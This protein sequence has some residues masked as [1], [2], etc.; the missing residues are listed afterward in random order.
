[1]KN[2]LEAVKE[3]H[4]TSCVR[5]RDKKPNDKY[6]IRFVRKQGCWSPVGRQVD[7]VGGQELSI[8][9]GCNEKGIILHELM[10]ALGF[11]H[12]QARTD[13]D[14]YI[15]VLWENVMPGIPV[16]FNRYNGGRLDFV[17][18]MYDF[19]SLMHYGNYAFSKNNKPTMISIKD[20]AMQ[21]GRRRSTL[22]DTDILQL[23][24]LYDC[25][26]K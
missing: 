11:W 14:E 17:G 16:N 24:A 19:E 23:N 4:K 20:P 26:S 7:G 6:W 13:R 22:S 9:D 2:I 25:E 3:I 21:F 15:N 18:G 5:F 10:H 12:E 1:R 8:G